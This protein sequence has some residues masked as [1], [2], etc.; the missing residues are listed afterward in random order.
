MISAA[1]IMLAN[2]FAHRCMLMSN[3]NTNPALK[4]KTKK[5]GFKLSFISYK[6]HTEEMALI[7]TDFIISISNYDKGVRI[8][9][10]SSDE[11]CYIP[12]T[13]VNYVLDAIRR[14]QYSHGDSVARVDQF[15]RQRKEQTK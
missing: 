8:V 12:D 6:N 1:N 4:I 10:I 5:E 7:N 13:K 3:L 2:V 15:Y 11:T 14:A 9:T